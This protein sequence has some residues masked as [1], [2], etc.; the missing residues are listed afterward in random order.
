MKNIRFLFIIIFSFITLKV[1]A[2]D[3][4]GIYDNYQVTYSPSTNTFSTGS[5][6]GDRVVLTKH[7]VFGGYSQ[8]VGRYNNTK[9]KCW[10]QKK[11]TQQI[12]EQCIELNLNSNFEFIWNSR[13]IGIDNENL[14]VYETKYIDKKFVEIE[15]TPDEVQK[16]FFDYDILRI[17]DFKKNTYTILSNNTEKNVLIINDTDIDF[18]KLIR[19]IVQ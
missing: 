13:L 8:Y 7:V 12:E 17:S 6:T 14:K 3:Y 18:H 19:K 15:I 11:D 9:C 10:D 16:I 1:F 4:E 5:I 2:L